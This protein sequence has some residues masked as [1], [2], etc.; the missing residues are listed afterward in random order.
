M[1]TF[2]NSFVV[3]ELVQFVQASVTAF[4]FDSISFSK[5]LFWPYV[6]VVLFG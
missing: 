2:L 5:F 6:N 1:N 3:F 4:Y